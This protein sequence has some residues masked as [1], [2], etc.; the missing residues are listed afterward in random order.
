MSEQVKQAV[1]RLGEAI[2]T[3]PSIASATFRAV[4]TSAEDSVRT[5]SRIRGFEV[6]HDEPVELGGTNGAPNPVEAVLAALGSCQ[7]IVYRAYASVLGLRLDEVRVDAI[8]DLDLRGLIGAAPVTA[9][10][11]RISFRT[12]I[13]SPEPE[14]RLRELAR[15]VEA[16]CPV[17]ETLRLPVDVSGILELA[18]PASREA[19]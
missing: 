5:S 7:A 11:Q 4:T 6:A 18:R 19:A 10:L 15:I 16:R 8:G 1:E 3:K 2:R 17:L 13:V 9:G 14:E 12:R